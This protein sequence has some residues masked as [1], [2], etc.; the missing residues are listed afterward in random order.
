MTLRIGEISN[1]VELTGNLP[2]AHQP[3]EQPAAHQP[4]WAERSRHRQRAEAEARD[5]SRT[6]AEERH[7]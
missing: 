3:S 6:A 7:V 1:E 2:P 5:T 4:S